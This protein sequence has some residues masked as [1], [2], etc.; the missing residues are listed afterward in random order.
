MSGLA[1]E[2]SGAKLWIKVATAI[3]KNQSINETLRAFLSFL[4]SNRVEQKRKLKFAHKNR[5]I[6]EILFS[7][8]LN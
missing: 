3:C 8:L 6:I 4:A 2:L 1:A 5:K 7:D